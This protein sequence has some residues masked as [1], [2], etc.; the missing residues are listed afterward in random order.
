MI[1]KAKFNHTKGESTSNS[2]LELLNESL[3]NDPFLKGETAIQAKHYFLP[4]DKYVTE[5]YS[6]GPSYIEHF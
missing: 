2:I 4:S 5:K 3:V 6:L 1:P